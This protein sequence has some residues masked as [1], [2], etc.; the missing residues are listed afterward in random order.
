MH[1]QIVAAVGRVFGFL[2]WRFSNE[3][4][5][6]HE[7]FHQLAVLS[8]D[9][10]QLSEKLP[11]APSCR[12]HAEGKIL[13]GRP[14]KADLLICDPTRRQEFN[15]EVSHVIELKQ[16]LSDAWDQF[17]PAYKDG[18]VKDPEA[19]I[20]MNRLR[21]LGSA[22]P[23]WHAVLVV[24][25]G[26]WQLPRDIHSRALPLL[27]SCTYPL[28]LVSYSEVGNRIVRQPLGP[29]HGTSRFSAG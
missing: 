24:I 19:T 10:Q 3:F 13:N 4:E 20:I 6:K 5:I 11:G 14:Q 18:K 25:Q 9:G 23:A 22:F 21:S 12:L 26:D 15:H 16:S 17:K 27:K 28:E 1:E 29:S 8:L 7:L 2:G